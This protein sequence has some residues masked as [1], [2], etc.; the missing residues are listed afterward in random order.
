M[1][2]HAAQRLPAIERPNGKLYRPRGIVA[3]PLG[4]EGEALCG[5]VVL[6]T[7][8]IER[9]RPL[10]QQVTRQQLGGGYL[11][12]APVCVWWRSTYR[13]G[14]PYWVDDEDHGRAGVWFSRID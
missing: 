1:A 7:H 11:A 12:E 4:G 2:D 8:D 3:W 13:H 6:G 10:A 5:V 9:A 14:R